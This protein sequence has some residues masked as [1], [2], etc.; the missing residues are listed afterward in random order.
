MDSISAQGITNALRDAELLADAIVAGLGGHR[1]LEAALAD[2]QR[3]R[4]SAIG[5]MY[6]FTMRLAS[7]RPRSLAG[8]PA[9]ITRFLGAFAGIEPPDSYFA[10]GNAVRVLGVRGVAALGA[11]AV[12]N[13]LGLGPRPS[14][15]R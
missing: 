12:R 13:A 4:D 10:T 9:E 1:P 5:A 11:A 2:H 7:F 15:S 8:R 14:R 6:D 3:R